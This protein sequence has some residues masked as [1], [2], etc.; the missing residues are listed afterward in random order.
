MESSTGSWYNSEYNSSW[1]AS[2]INL[3][4]LGLFPELAFD[5]FLTI[6]GEDSS[7]PASEHPSAVSGAIDFTAEFETGGGSNFIL[8]DGVGGAWYTPFPESIRPTP[9]WPSRATTSACWWPS[10][11]QPA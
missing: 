2:G 1:N 5:S 11:P 3:A 8:N 4:F 7:T 10:S 9:T 6:G